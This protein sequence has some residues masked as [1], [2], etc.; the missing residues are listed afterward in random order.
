[1]TAIG[2]GLENFIA[3]PPSSIRAKRLGLLC[4]P[5]SVDSRLRHARDLLAQRL[6]GQLKALFSPQHGFYAEKQDNMVESGHLS[7]E[8]LGIP[9]FSLYG[10]VRRPTEAMFDLIDTLIVDLQDVG[11]R[12]Y[13]FIYTMAYCMQAAK[14]FGK[15]VLVL[16]RPNPIGGHRVEGNLLHDDL[17]SFVG[18]YPIPM[19][20]G[21]TI[22]ELAGLF[23]AHYG[24]NCRLEVIP[25]KGW[26]RRMFFQDTG[27]IWVAPSPNLPTPASA[28]VYPGQV[29]WEGTNVSEGRG[30]CQPFELFGAPF[31]DP[32]RLRSSLAGASSDGFRLRE[33]VFEPTFNKWR[34][35]RCNGF[36]LHVT[37]P[38]RYN[39]YF[40]TLEILKAVYACWPE[41]FRWKPPPYEYEHVKAPFDLISGDRQIRRCIEENASLD[42]LRT[43]WQ[44]EL[45]KFLDL[46]RRF[47]LYER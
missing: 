6:P 25:M 10:R 30:T 44:P 7:D 46:G 43:A 39:P 37:D 42:D 18:L 32:R 3:S 38:G 19:R 41:Q 17:T 15:S 12:V 4:N 14:R 47:Y 29:L 28:M 2:I 34:G 27:R 20:H 23:N 1:M 22:G 5:A 40:S 35:R 31:I 21:L 33:H 36:Q 11:T 24:I 8:H 9:V 16:D 26:R 13:T 45:K